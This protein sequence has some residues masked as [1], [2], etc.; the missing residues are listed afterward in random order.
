MGAKAKGGISFILRADRMDEMLL[1]LRLTLA[2]LC[3]FRSGHIILA[4][5]PGYSYR[6]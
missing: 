1:Y 6:T 5:L 3:V 2:K 4:L